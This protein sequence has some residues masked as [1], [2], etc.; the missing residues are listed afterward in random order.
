MRDH[1]SLRTALILGPG[2]GDPRFS[3]Y[4]ANATCEFFVY[5][6]RD[7]RASVE[8]P[9]NF[10][11]HW[12]SLSCIRQSRRSVPGTIG[13]C[14]NRL[15][16]KKLNEN[17]PL[18]I[19]CISPRQC[20]PLNSGAK[21][22]DYHCARALSQI[23]QLT[24]VHFLEPGAD[25]PTSA[26]MPFCKRIISVKKPRSYTLWNLVRGLVGTWPVTI[27]NYISEEMVSVLEQL[28]TQE[29]FDILHLDSIHLAP[30]E[31]L[32]VDP[33]RPP[34]RCVYDWHNIESEAMKRYSVEVKSLARRFYASS[35]VQRL[36]KLERALLQN[37]FG[38]VVCSKREE[39]QLRMLVPGARVT[40]V[41]NGVDT[42]FFARATVE[43]RWPP[44]NF[45]FVGA[46]N[47]YPNVEAAIVFVRD[48]W[49][50]LRSLFP[51]CR[52][53]LVGSD[54]VPAVLALQ[55]KEGVAVTGTVEDVRVFYH[56]ADVAVVPLRLGGGTRLKILEA[57]AAGVPVVSTSVGAEGLEVNPGYNI[58]IADD[59]TPESWARAIM[60]LGEP[61][62]RR[63]ELVAAATQLVR[64]RYDWAVT[65]KLLCDTYLDWLG[66]LA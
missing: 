3:R 22:R 7:E 66:C 54:P 60:S 21:L 8:D 55:D 23:A 40:A 30:Y 14:R 63:E 28:K 1:A 62:R 24:Y 35:T 9:L 59:R 36:Q 38:H 29:N 65:G 46:M 44:S 19:L 20:W 45:I 50:R 39:E 27:L 11:N 43:L 51:G 16:R 12:L 32:F 17:G 2:L 26:D 57:M 42:A 48:I 58:L 6:K 34:I 5:A 61:E 56:L 13:L 33:G 49:P 15:E 52:L 64:E 18:R 41:P 25:P 47:Y 31:S 10:A 37:A 4:K 53:T